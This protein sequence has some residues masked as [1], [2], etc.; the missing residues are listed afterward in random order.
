MNSIDRFTKRAKQVLY[1]AQE[2]ARY[3]N[4]PYVGTEH[5]LLGL[6]RDQDHVAGHVLDEL[7]VK[8]AQARSAVKFI[9]GYGKVKRNEDLELTADTKKIIE[10]ALEEGRKL[11][12]HYVGT[13][14]L[15]LGL[16]R[17]GEG[18]AAGVLEIM[19]VS[20]EQ[21]RTSVLRHLHPG[22]SSGLERSA[23]PKQ[24]KTP[25]LDA[26]STDLTRIAEAGRLDP[27]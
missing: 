26:L 23:Q 11:N 3:F 25:Y 27:V 14:H 4:H 10:Y 22:P 1:Y 5:I 7:G 12:H 19:G 17:K 20:L 8:H 24:S 15:L 6:I 9:V 18:V 13:E 2:E 16:V 21:V